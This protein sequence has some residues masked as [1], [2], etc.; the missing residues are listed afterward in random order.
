MYRY[1]KNDNTDYISEW[2]SKGLLG[3]VI[4]P[5]PTCNNSLALGLNYIG[6]KT[7]VKI[8]WKLFK[9]RY[10]YI[11]SWRNNKYLQCL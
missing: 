9:A 4:K 5:P 1:L 2:K 11:Y 6:N 10:N 3:E 8:C 7:R